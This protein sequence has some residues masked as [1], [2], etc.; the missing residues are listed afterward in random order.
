MFAVSGAQAIPGV[1][2]SLSI[3]REASGILVIV[4]RELERA[5]AAA[6]LGAHEMSPPYVP[7]APLEERVL[8]VL[9]TAGIAVPESHRVPATLPLPAGLAGNSVPLV[10]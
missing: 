10:A 5:G 3:P 4:A 8:K 9:R 1:F 2:G 7:S 6:M